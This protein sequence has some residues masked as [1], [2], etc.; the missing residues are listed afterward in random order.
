MDAVGN[1]LGKLTLEPV[2]EQVSGTQWHSLTFRGK[3]TGRRWIGW[4][5]FA[6]ETRPQWVLEE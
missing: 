3:W 5:N 2:W 6:G 4:Q 1:G